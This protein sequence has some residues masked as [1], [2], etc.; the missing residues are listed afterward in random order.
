[1]FIFCHLIY[2][3]NYKLVATSVLKDMMFRKVKTSQ[4]FEDSEK[5]INSLQFSQYV[6]SSIASHKTGLPVSNLKEFDLSKN[7][8]KKVKQQLKQFK[9]EI[10]KRFKL[11]I[12]MVM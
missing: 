12:M 11:L 5:F 8:L 10:K 7:Y 3:D 6:E 1:M 2:T 9:K 4:T